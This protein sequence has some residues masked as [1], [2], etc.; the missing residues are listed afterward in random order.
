MFIYLLL[1]YLL[2]S[3]I[4][5]IHIYERNSR[6]RN[7]IIKNIENDISLQPVTEE[8]LDKI[9]KIEEIK[10]IDSPWYEKLFSVIGVTAFISMSVATV[11]QT[12]DTYKKEK[13]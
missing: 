5:Y 6:Y 10:R 8:I 3:V 13:E 1:L 2:F 4:F 7:K 11:I 12:Y 9:K